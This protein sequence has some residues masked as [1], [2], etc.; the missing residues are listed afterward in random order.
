MR[1]TSM[2]RL[3]GA[4]SPA[5]V[6]VL[7][8]AAVLCLVLTGVARADGAPPGAD[9]AQGRLGQ[10]PRHGEFV[11]VPVDGRAAGPVKAWV[12]Y[13]ER[14]DEAPVVIVIHEIFGLTDWVRAVADQLAADGFIAIAPD[15]LSGLGPDGGDTGSFD[16]GTVR[17][18]VRGLKPEDVTAALAA[19]RAYGAGLPASNGNTGVVGYCWGGTQS[20]RFAAADGVGAAVVYYGSTPDA[21]T[22]ANVKAPVLG[23]YGEDDARV[24]QTIPQAEQALGERFEKHVYPA[25]GH[26]FLRQQDGRGGANKAATDAAWPRTVEFFRERLEPK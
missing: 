9:G 16:E 7:V 20:F 13:P 12:V 1:S 11:D 18:A 17:D 22:L 21:A 6:A 23:L 3:A 25:A 26:G 10:S 5:S 14:K 24:N 4:S 8:A 15:L 2:I 19:V